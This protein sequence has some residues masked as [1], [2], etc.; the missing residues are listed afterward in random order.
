MTAC[1]PPARKPG[2]PAI[3]DLIHRFGLEAPVRTPDGAGGA[4]L[5]WALVADVWG[6]LTATS[7]DER[8][9]ADRLSGRVTHTIAIRH[10]PGL[11][12]DYRLTLGARRFTI[13]AILDRD[14]RHR[15]LECRCEEIVT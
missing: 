6:S 13:H 10:R 9:N 12:P 8:L 3:G 7:G 4:T 11:T 2:S 14:G 1:A 15:F 5:A